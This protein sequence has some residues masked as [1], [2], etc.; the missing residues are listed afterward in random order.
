NPGKDT[1]TLSP[2]SGA[3]LCTVQTH[4]V[5]ECLENIGSAIVESRKARN[6]NQAMLAKNASVT[7]K[8]VSFIENGKNVELDSLFQILS[9][10]DINPW[11]MF[12]GKAPRRFAED[13]THH[14]AHSLLQDLLEAGKTEG[15][16]F[17]LDP[18]HKA[19][20]RRKS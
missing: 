8:T 16:M 15:V 2:S 17:V 5:K 11:E 12:G 18:L 19:Y 6:W 14:H 10:L 20:V 9:A 13:S 3:I 7:R 1:C 4:V